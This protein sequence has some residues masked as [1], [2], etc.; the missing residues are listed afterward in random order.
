MGGGGGRVYAAI[1]YST[2]SIQW[3][4]FAN[5]RQMLTLTAMINTVN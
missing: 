1:F 4:Q 5:K 3:V 2:L